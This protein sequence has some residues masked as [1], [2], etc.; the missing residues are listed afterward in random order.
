MNKP[1]PPVGFLSRK[2]APIPMSQLADEPTH[3]PQ[4]HGASKALD[5]VVPLV[6]YDRRERIVFLIRGLVPRRRPVFAAGLTDPGILVG[7]SVGVLLPLFAA[8]PCLFDNGY[9]SLLGAWPRF[10]RHYYTAGLTAGI[11][12]LAAVLA[13]FKATPAVLTRNE[14]LKKRRGATP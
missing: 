8:I 14:G 13:I 1:L 4:P 2:L 12:L 6:E 7:F 5:D 9:S 3:G 11:S 10:G